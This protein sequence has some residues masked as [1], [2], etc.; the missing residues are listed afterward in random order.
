MTPY[1]LPLLD[2]MFY[3]GIETL[4]LLLRGMATVPVR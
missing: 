1:F 4:V 3:T 2:R